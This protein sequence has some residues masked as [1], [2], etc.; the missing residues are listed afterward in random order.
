MDKHLIITLSKIVLRHYLGMGNWVTNSSDETLPIDNP[1]S[2]LA[3]GDV[4]YRYDEDSMTIFEEEIC[5][6]NE[7]IGYFCER[8]FRRKVVRLV[9]VDSTYCRTRLEAIE[10]CKTEIENDIAYHSKYLPGLHAL[11]EEL[12]TSR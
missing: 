3:V 8:Y 6:I 9:A 4:V 12:Q 5:V 10:K 7:G 2:D 11:L 1:L